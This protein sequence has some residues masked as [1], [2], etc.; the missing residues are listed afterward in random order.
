MSATTPAG[1]SRLVADYDEALARWSQA[2][3]AADALP[4]RQ[5]FGSEEERRHE[6][7]VEGLCAS[8]QATW[9]RQ[10]RGWVEACARE[11]GSLP[12]DD[13]RKADWVRLRAKPAAVV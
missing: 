11:I 1:W 13:V 5:S 12:V 4:V 8:L 2:G 9:E 3:A 7:A 6:E 10:L